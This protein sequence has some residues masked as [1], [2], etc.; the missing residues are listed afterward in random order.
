MKPVLVTV[1][2]VQRDEDGQDY[3]IELISTGKYYEKKNARYVVYEESEI[4]GMAGVTTVIKILADSVLLLRFGQIHQKQLF[5]KGKV[6]RTAY[7]IPVGTINI[8][9]KT[10]ELDVALHDGIG[11]IKIGYDVILDGIGTNYNEL[12]ITVQEDK[13]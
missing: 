12:T 8:S 6:F 13:S 10:Y 1:H 2:S 9:L 4:T 11:T 7:E 3:T 5:R